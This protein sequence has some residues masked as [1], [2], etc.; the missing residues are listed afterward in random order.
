MK[1]ALVDQNILFDYLLQRQLFV[2]PAQILIQLGIDQKVKLYVTS[3][4]FTNL[5][6][7]LRRANPHKKVVEKLQALSQ[8]FKII[9]VDENVVQQSLASDFTD[10]EDAVQH[11]AAAAQPE[12]RYIITRNKKD[13]QHSTLTILDASEFLAQL[14]G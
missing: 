13:F 9:A 1:H 7:V 2:E 11:Y 4:S 8:W 3:L 14:S 5:Y 6:Y 10:F 12:I